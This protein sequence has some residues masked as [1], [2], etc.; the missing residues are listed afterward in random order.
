[1]NRLGITAAGIA[2][3]LAFGALWHGPGG[4][5]EAL[6]G[7]AEAV[8]R[9]TLDRYEMTSVATRIERDPLS[10]TLILSGPSDSFQRAELVR[11]LNEVPGVARVRWDARSLPQ[12]EVR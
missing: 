8:A 6:A 1:M 2:A 12:E 5:G 11:I 9:A 3:T 7:R 10:R 4:A